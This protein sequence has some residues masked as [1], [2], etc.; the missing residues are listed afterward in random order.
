M[1]TSSFYESNEAL[2]MPDGDIGD[3][4]ISANGTQAVIDSKAVT[5]AKFQDINSGS[6]LGRASAGI[7]PVQELTIGSGLTLTGTTLSATGG[8]GGGGGGITDGDKGDITVSASGNTWTIDADAVTFAK[9]QNLDSGRI[10]GRHSAGIGDAEQISIGAGLNLSAG[11]LSS[12]V[13]GVTDGDK[14]DIT[15]S[16]T[17][18]TW[19]VDNDAI[20]FAKMQNVATGVLLGRSTAGTG[21]IEPITI[22]S[23]LSLSA[24]VLTATGGGGATAPL[25]LAG[26]TVTDPSTPLTITQ[27][28]NDAADTFTGLSSTIT[29]TASAAASRLI[30]FRVGAS[31]RFAVNKNGALLL[32]NGTRSIWMRP[33]SINATDALTFATNF[34]ANGLVRVIA[35]SWVAGSGWGASEGQIDNRVIIDTNN[36]V[37]VG[38]SLGIGFSANGN[39]GFNDLHSAAIRW[40][41]AGSLGIRGSSGTVGATLN[42][43]E[44]TEPATPAANQIVLYAA[45]NGSGISVLRVKDDSGAVY[46]LGTGGGGGGSPGGSSGDIQF[47]NAGNFG[48]SLLKQDT[49]TIEQRAGTSAQ[50]FRVYNTFTDAL[51]YERGFARWNSNVFEIG[52]ENLGT[53]V[54]RDVRIAFATNLLF[55][56]ASNSSTLTLDGGF[57]SN[58]VYGFQF[59]ATG[60]FGIGSWAGVTM[61]ALAVP[62][63]WTG[64]LNSSPDIQIRRNAA[65]ILSIRGGSDSAGGALNLLEQTAPAAPGVNQMTVYAEDVS[66]R[67]VLRAIDSDGKVSQLTGT[68]LI[69]ISAAYTFGLSDDGRIVYHPSADTTARTFT[70]PANASNPF[71]VGSVITVINGNGAGTVTIAITTDT[72]RQAGTGTVGSRTLAANGRAVLVKVTTTEWQIDGVGLT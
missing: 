59:G 16:G 39:V 46:T 13:V 63:G 12:T 57:N 36:G 44:Q 51:N 31:D 60:V 9:L 50:T 19:T 20:T 64:T 30:D 65:G 33:Q 48:G 53:G 67:S 49:N 32:S 47:N 52:T 10:V 38:S 69:E 55:K 2:N 61:S 14:G 18:L 8:G 45:D 5:F 41:A 7:G 62:L 34:T 37:M 72:L 68:P 3:I 4:I 66:G 35:G 17:G 15:V 71:P 40:I 70:I 24:G 28:W 1:S 27:T 6:I 23:G 11:V 43:L 42:F 22:G 56:D 54:G 29:D 58:N 26:G 21:D 25:T